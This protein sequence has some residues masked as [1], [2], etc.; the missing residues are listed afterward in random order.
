MTG[1]ISRDLVQTA[2]K[3]VLVPIFSVVYVNRF[4]KHWRLS[5]R[6]EV[7]RAHVLS[8]ADGTL[9]SSAADMRKRR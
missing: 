2:A 3:F 7:L 8:Y 6:G 4:L 5:G 9:S 1:V